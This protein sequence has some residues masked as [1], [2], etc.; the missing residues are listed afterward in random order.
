MKKLLLAA[1]VLF[2]LCGC[3]LNDLGDRTANAM[4]TLKLA[5]HID[6]RAARAG[7]TLTVDFNHDSKTKK[8]IS[9]IDETG[10]NIVIRTENIGVY[11]IK[12]EVAHPL[13][14]V[15]P[16]LAANGDYMVKMR[17]ALKCSMTR[18]ETGSGFRLIFKIL[19]PDYEM[20]AMQKFGSWVS[21]Y[22][23]A[24][25]LAGVKNGKTSTVLT[26]DGVPV[27]S[28]GNNGRA[29]YVDIYG[30]RIPAGN[31]KYDGVVSTAILDGKSRLIFR[32]GADICI[33]DR[34]MTV[35]RSC[36]GYTSLFGMTKEKKNGNEKFMFRLTGRPDITVK[37]FKGVTG[38]G[39]KNMRLFGTGIVRFDGDAVFKT[40]VRESGGLMWIIFIHDPA[41]KFRRFFSSGDM[42]N[43]VFYKG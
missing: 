8:F 14:N 35:G 3:A 37:T 4:T 23:A 26:F 27:Y 6:I 30:V 25:R 28:K 41:Y 22:T 5:T 33:E 15:Q 21:A 2:V 32:D 40:E 12:S 19:E 20:S 42:L 31:V 29:D 16:W 10:K 11:I 17:L 13:V 24:T 9:E 43:V 1:A 34:K 39:I 38:L 18:V 7:D 36:A